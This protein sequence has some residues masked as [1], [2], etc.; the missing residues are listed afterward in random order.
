LSSSLLNARP[1]RFLMSGLC[2]FRAYLS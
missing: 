1:R 2:R